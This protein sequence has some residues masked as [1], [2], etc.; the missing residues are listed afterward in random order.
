[1]TDGHHSRRCLN[2]AWDGS[3]RSNALDAGN[4]DGAAAA[5]PSCCGS[6]PLPESLMICPCGRRFLEGLEDDREPVSGCPRGSWIFL[7]PAR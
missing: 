3:L 6:L 5:A 7:G 1:M 2:T 4:P